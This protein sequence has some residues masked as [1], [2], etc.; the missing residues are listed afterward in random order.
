MTTT[1]P[2]AL[3]AASIE[4]ATA[5]AVANGFTA[6]DRT[7]AGLVLAGM[8][9]MASCRVDVIGDFLSGYLEQNAE[10]RE[11]LERWADRLAAAVT[12]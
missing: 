3:E 9:L 5:Y 10:A 6:Q 4:A 11:P 1:A 12:A 2:T 8:A 7:A